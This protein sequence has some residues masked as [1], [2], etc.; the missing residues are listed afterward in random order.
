[1]KPFRSLDQFWPQALAELGS[2][3]ALLFAGFL[4]SVL[5][6]LFVLGKRA[7]YEDARGLFTGLAGASLLIFVYT[8]GS[9]LNETFFLFT[10]SAFVGMGLGY[11]NAVRERDKA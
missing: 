11:E 1:M 6:C 10:Y 3:G 5:I 8:M 7:G 4:L 9:G 2:V